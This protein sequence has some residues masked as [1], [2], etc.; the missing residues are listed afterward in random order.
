MAALLAS[1]P[2]VPPD[3]RGRSSLPL[4]VGLVALVAGFGAFLVGV[5]LPDSR[6]PAIQVPHL[7]VHRAAAARF[8]VVQE[9]TRV[10]GG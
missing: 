1:I 6:S 9:V 2:V 5:T 3:R 4:T 10:S 7:P 8:D